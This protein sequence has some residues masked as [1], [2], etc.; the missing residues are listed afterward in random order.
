[1][2]LYP[3]LTAH[4]P[5]PIPAAMVSGADVRLALQAGLWEALVDD[6]DRAA[7][8][9]TCRDARD[10]ADELQDSTVLP[11]PDTWDSATAIAAYHRRL[12]AVQS[13]HVRYSCDQA[14]DARAAQFVEAYSAALGAALPADSCTIGMTFERQLGASFAVARL[15]RR[16]EGRRK[17]AGQLSQPRTAA[18]AV[19]GA[20]AHAMA[21]P[22]AAA[23][24]RRRSS[25]ARWRVCR[26]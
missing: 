16:C 19:V 23:G 3:D 12:G 25:R 4:Y 26:S 20:R 10:F 17:G 24:C 5:T 6:D 8:R 15:V 18:D 2:S 1:M 11:G 13:L 7:M 9:A 22:E 21:H 14:D